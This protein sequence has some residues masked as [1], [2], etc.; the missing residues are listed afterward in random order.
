[1]SKEIQ[2]IGT[3]G[4]THYAQVSRDSDGKF[5]NTSTVAFETYQTANVANYAISMT[6]QGTASGVYEGDLPASL[7]GVAGLSG[8]MRQRAG[9]SPAESDDPVAAGP[10]NQ[11]VASLGAGAITDATISFPAEAAGRPTTFLAAVRRLWEW[12]CNKR[13]RDRSTGAL[14]LLGHDGTTVL[15]TK[16]QSTSGLVDTIS[17]GA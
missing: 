5:W 4:L 11:S 9:G 1:M 8:T 15:E 12:C 13:T 14:T 10:L 16:A 17:E 3:T 7:V 2:A 6:E